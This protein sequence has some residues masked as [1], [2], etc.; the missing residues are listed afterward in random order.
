M[1]VLGLV[2]I[3]GG[4]GGGGGEG[5][6]GMKRDLQEEQAYSKLAKSQSILL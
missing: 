3:Y 5:V 1:V 2:V 4:G 6:E